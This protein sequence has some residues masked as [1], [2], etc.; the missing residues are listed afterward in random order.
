[1][2]KAVVSYGG[3]DSMAL[4]SALLTAIQTKRANQT[5]E[6]RQANQDKY[7]ALKE[8]RLRK[9]HIIRGVCP[10]CKSK[11]IR[12]KK[13]KKNDYKRVWTCTKCSDIHSM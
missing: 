13:D 10:S 5:E 8:E 12:G 7:L 4:G 2:K 3:G 1:M 9:A 11:L 6:E